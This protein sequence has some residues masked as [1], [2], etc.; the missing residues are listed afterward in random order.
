MHGKSK[1]TAFAALAAGVLAIS[2]SAIF[3][4]WTHMPGVASAFYRLFIAAILLWIVLLVKRFPIAHLNGRS[5]LL[6]S[7]GGIFFAG[8][9]GLYNVAVL[10]TA[11]GS[12]TF[13]ANV[14]PIFVGLLT[15]YATR[16]LPSR[17]F[18]T[19]LAI[20]FAGAFLIVSMDFRSRQT[21][22]SADLLAVMAAIC[23]AGYLF[24]TEHVRGKLD[25]VILAALSTTASAI[26][27]LFF[28][29]CA[30]VSLTVPGIASLAA[31]IG[32]GVICQF[33]GYFCLTYALGHLPATATSIV[34]LGVAPLTAINAR[35]VFNERMMP[36]QL[37]GGGFI[38]IAVWIVSRVPNTGRQDTGKA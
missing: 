32:L 20:A 28:T 12:A 26:S 36:L 21:G 17:R 23:F 6:S 15:W 31:L 38:L 7:L 22:F 16:K 18:C 35:I 19:A 3:V 33:A 5:I 8:D 13:L 1:L 34:L 11:A 9:V 10:R 25:T 30:Q 27:L 4:R 37:L 2:W 14:S 29:V 24:I